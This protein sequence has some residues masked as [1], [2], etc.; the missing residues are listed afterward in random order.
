MRSITARDAGRE[1]GEE[2]LNMR[3]T[4]EVERPLGQAIG[5]KEDLAMYLERWGDARVI[6]VTDEA[7][8]QMEIKAAPA[9][10]EP[11]KPEKKSAAKR[12]RAPSVEE[13][14]AYCAERDNGIDAEAFVDFYKSKG[15]VVGRSP[16]RD[17]KAAVRTWERDRAGRE[18]ERGVIEHTD[19]VSPE[20]VASIQRLMQGVAG[21]A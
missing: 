13:V 11:V 15:W 20:A 16:M 3:I 1:E 8:E 7:A 5:I 14:A 4:I 19:R 6:S 12:F 18:S 21:R 9:E 2:L 17:W 10:P